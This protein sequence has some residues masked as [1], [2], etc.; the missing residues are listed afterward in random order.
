MGDENQAVMFGG[1]TSSG[2]TYDI[3]VLL[4]PTMVSPQ[5]DR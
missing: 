1:A 3:R 4:L 5:L 2:K